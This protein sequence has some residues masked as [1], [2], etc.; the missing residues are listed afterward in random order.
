MRKF[1]LAVVYAMLVTCTATA[2]KIFANGKCDTADDT[3]SIFTEYTDLNPDIYPTFKA[4][5]DDARASILADGIISID[6]KTCGD[7]LFAAMSWKCDYDYTEI[8]PIPSDPSIRRIPLDEV[9]MR[10]GYNKRFLHS[11]ENE[12]RLVGPDPMESADAPMSYGTRLGEIMYDADSWLKDQLFEQL[13]SDYEVANY[14]PLLSAMYFVPEIVFSE[15]GDDSNSVYVTIDSSKV[16]VMAPPGDLVADRFAKEITADQNTLLDVPEV[17][18]LSLAFEAAFWAK[19]II[20][21]CSV[22]GDVKRESLPV[23][24]GHTPTTHPTSLGIVRRVEGSDHRIDFIEGG[25]LIQPDLFER[26]PNTRDVSALNSKLID[27]VVSKAPRGT[28]NW[29]VNVGETTYAGVT[30][31]V[32]RR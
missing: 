31:S 29:T 3:Y 21:H 30:I 12:W 13:L 23:S 28:A 15:S 18:I 14:T 19:K 4:L 11:G 9:S 7:P 32:V 24:S 2:E 26:N 25:V 6:M 27:D 10:I 20:D 8:P 5:L 17:S 16:T 1:Q 22:P